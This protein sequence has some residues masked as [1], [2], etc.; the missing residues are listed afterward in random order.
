MLKEFK[1][2]VLRGNVVDLAVA[3][4]IGAAFAK[5]VSAFTE[6]VMQ[7]FINAAGGRESIGL[8][9]FIRS[10]DAKTFVDFGALLTALINFLIVAAVVYFVVVVPVTRLMQRRERGEEP[11][12]EAP[13]EDIVLLREIRDSLL[14]RNI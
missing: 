10:N 3:V 2:F 12:V 11:P 8:G 13:T 7:P 6:K 5:V 9:F 4:V 14:A 1:A